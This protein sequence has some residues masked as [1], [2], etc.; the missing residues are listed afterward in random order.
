[1]EVTTRDTEQRQH[2]VCLQLKITPM[3]QCLHRE[4]R[5]RAPG[6]T[7]YPGVSWMKAHPCYRHDPG[8]T[9]PTGERLLPSDGIHCSVH[10]VMAYGELL[11]ALPQILQTF[12]RHRGFLTAAARFVG[13]SVRRRYTLLPVAFRLRRRALLSPLP[14]GPLSLF[15]SLVRS[16]PSGPGLLSVPRHPPSQGN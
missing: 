6:Q 11:A 15:Q 14:L 1:M 5:E 4:A 8:S 3:C 10:S 12:S 2:V 13:R 7:S 16:P 9:L